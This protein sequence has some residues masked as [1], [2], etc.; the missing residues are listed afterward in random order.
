MFVA[1]AFRTFAIDPPY[2]AR[3][4]RKQ[5]TDR[6][7]ALIEQMSEGYARDWADY[8]RRVGVMEGLTA[9]IEIC[10]EMEKQE[11]K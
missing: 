7:V 9:A 11:R 4:L 8:Q 10:D 2:A 1:E 3:T 6:R 5:L